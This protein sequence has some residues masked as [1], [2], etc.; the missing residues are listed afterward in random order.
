MKMSMVLIIISL[1]ISVGMCAAIQVDQKHIFAGE[2]FTATFVIDA[3]LRE[4]EIVFNFVGQEKVVN[5][6]EMEKG[7]YTTKITFTAPNKPGT[8]EITS[9]EASTS[10]IVEKPMITVTDVKMDPYAINPGETSQLV[11]S[12][13]NVGDFSVYNVKAKV[14]IVGSSDRYEFNKEWMPLFEIM[15]PGAELTRRIDITSKQSASGL[16]RIELTISYE[17]DGE[18]HTI[19]KYAEIQVGGFPLVEVII[20]IIVLIVVGRFVLTRVIG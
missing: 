11:F 9:K 12:I 2:Q 3:P 16:E 19:N 7:T 13:R 5:I 15:E 1:M 4:G 6:P 18:V 20:L 8:Y 10:V 17:Y 14:N